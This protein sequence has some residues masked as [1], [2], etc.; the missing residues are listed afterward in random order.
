MFTENYHEQLSEAEKLIHSQEESSTFR[1]QYSK[2]SKEEIIKEAE[3]LIQTA[4]VK[5]SYQKLLELKSIF[6]ALVSAEKPAQIKAWI[7]ARK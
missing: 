1:D 6:E 2:L 3:S 4:D 5:A 7:D